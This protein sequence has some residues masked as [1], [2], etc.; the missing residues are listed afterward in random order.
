MTTV[1][2]LNRWSHLY[3]LML[4]VVDGDVHRR[5]DSR[6]CT[7]LGEARRVL[8]RWRDEHAIPDQHVHDNSDTDLDV[9]F[10]QMDVDFDGVDESIEAGTVSCPKGRAR[11]SLPGAFVSAVSHHNYGMNFITFKQ[12]VELREGLLLPDRPPAKGLS[13]IHPF[14]T[15]DAHRRRLKPKPVKVANPFTPTIRPVA[16]SCR[17]T[18]SRSCPALVLDQR[19]SVVA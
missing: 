18:S 12:Y 5:I 8:G 6:F 3:H 4:A 16:K 17:T 19:R 7:S 14:P 1:A 11:W 10:A 13:R 2:Y 9:L 15:T